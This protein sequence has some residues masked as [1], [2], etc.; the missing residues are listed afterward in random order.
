VS[1]AFPYT[2]MKPSRFTQRFFVM[3]ITPIALRTSRTC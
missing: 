1:L 2:P 3:C